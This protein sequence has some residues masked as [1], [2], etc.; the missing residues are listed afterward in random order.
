MEEEQRQWQVRACLLPIHHDTHLQN[1][2]GHYGG[3]E[4]EDREDVDCG[5]RHPQG[6]REGVSI[7]DLV[8]GTI[9]LTSER[10]P[11]K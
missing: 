1:V 7:H 9:D 11:I 3:Q 10:N 5:G 2:R 4:A 6:R 8:L